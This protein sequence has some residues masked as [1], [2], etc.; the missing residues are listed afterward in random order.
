MNAFRGLAWRPWPLRCVLLS[1]YAWW[2]GALP[3]YQVY[4]R[5]NSISS[6]LIAFWYPIHSL[7]VASWYRFGWCPSSH[8]GQA[9][10]RYSICSICFRGLARCPWPLSCYLFQSYP[11]P[12]GRTN[13][14]KH[15]PPPTS[16]PARFVF[17]PLRF[18]ASMPVVYCSS[19]V[20]YTGISL[21]CCTSD[22]SAVPGVMRMMSCVIFVLIVLL[23]RD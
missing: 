20:V 7:F 8:A 3:Q 2:R 9:C 19:S 18:C 23:Y 1:S 22:T 17:F 12:R 6:L 10:T 21:V 13:F 16:K 15:K 11:W 5:Y 4:T 14:N